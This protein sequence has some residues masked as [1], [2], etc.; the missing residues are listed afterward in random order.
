MSKVVWKGPLHGGITQ[1][2]LTRFLECPYRFYLYAGLG[3]TEPGEPEPNL[4]WGDICHKGLELIIEKPYEISEFTPEDWAEVHQGIEEH[5]QRDWPGAPI[6]FL[7]SIKNMITLYND[8]YKQEYGKFVTENKFSIE[9]KTVGGNRVTLRGKADGWQEQ[10]HVL[11]E[12]KCKGKIDIQQTI[13]ETPTDLQVTVYSFVL[14]TRIIIYDLIR[15]PDT[16]WS[17]P[18]KRQYENPINYIRSLYTN[19]E[20][21]DF[22]INTKR[23]RWIQQV[24]IYVT[25]EQVQE[26]MALTVDPLIDKLCNYW[27]YV[28]QPE[29]DHNNPKFYNHLFYR[30]PIRHFDPSRTQSYKCSYWNLLTG[31]IDMEDLIPVHSFYAELDE[32]D[33]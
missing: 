12:H 31:A 23:H 16:A 25:D 2:L 28:S 22:P 4:V 20:W 33:A 8:S 21:D 32:Y 26:T 15:I 6:T 9:H 18:P 30:T 11:V 7:P 19:R 10:N 17:L 5:Q 13:R 3:L 24:P 29:F 1:S 14:G 27:E